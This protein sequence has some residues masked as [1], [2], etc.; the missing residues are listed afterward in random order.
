MTNNLVNIFRFLSHKK[1]VKVFND[2]RVKI[3]SS[4]WL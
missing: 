4:V 1:S 2:F 3:K